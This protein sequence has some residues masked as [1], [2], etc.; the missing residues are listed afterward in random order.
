V[1]RCPQH[2]LT[3]PDALGPLNHHDNATGLSYEDY[4]HLGDRNLVIF[5][6]M[7]VLLS[8]IMNMVALKFTSF[9]WLTLTYLQRRAFFL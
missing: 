8:T 9:A 6:N 4:S 2:T 7:L 1:L 3:T 5:C